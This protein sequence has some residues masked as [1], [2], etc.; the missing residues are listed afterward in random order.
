MTSRWLVL[1][2]L[3]LFAG[4]AN[5]QQIDCQRLAQAMQS[6]QYDHGRLQDMRAVYETECSSPSSNQPLDTYDSLQD[7]FYAIGICYDRNAA[8]QIANLTTQ[9]AEL[10]VNNGVSFDSRP[11]EQRIRALAQKHCVRVEGYPTQ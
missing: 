3:A 11:Y 6:G 7:V 1:L 8:I 5:A 2:I 10:Q 4:R 9:L